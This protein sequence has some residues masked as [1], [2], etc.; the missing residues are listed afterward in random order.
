MLFRQLQEKADMQVVAVNDLGTLEN[1]EYLL[2]HDTV[3][4]K[5]ERGLEGVRFFQEQ[6]PSKLPWKDLDIDI[7]PTFFQPSRLDRFAT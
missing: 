2:S 1:L 4:G 7:F 5:F 6:N 3:Y